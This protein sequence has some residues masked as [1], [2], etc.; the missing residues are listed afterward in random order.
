[1]TR[2]RVTRKKLSDKPISVGFGDEDRA[3]VEEAAYDRREQS[4]SAFIRA[5]AVKE[6]KRVLASA[7]K[8]AA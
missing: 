6:A 1:M 3:L 4:L 2:R 5:A 7:L 8:A